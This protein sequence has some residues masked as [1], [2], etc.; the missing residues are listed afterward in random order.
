MEYNGNLVRL[1]TEIHEYKGKQIIYLQYN[2]KTL[3]K[4][5]FA[6]LFHNVKYGC[7]LSGINISET[8]LLQLLHYK[9]GFDNE[10][11]AQVCGYR[12]ATV[13]IN[14]DYE[15]IDINYHS[16]VNLYLEMTL[17]D[18]ETIEVIADDKKQCLIRR[19]N[20]YNDKMNNKSVNI[21][22]EIFEFM[23][24]F[25]Q[26]DIFG[27]RTMLLSRLL[28]Q[29]LLFKSNI[30]VTQYQSIDRLIFLD[31]SN[32]KQKLRKKQV[33]LFNFQ[34][35]LSFQDY[36]FMKLIESYEALDYNFQLILDTNITPKYRVLN[37]LN[38][39]F[40][41]IS[42]SELEIMLA[43]ISRKTIERALVQLQKEVLIE[44]VG[45][46]KAT[47]YKVK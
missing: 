26:S 32:G 34:S 19:C 31:R 15:F 8:K 23:Y 46:G 16:I 11:E 13:L 18:T 6:A 12:D 45:Q 3:E 43:D 28:M 9:K 38:R 29:L 27:K 14:E 24:Q 22:T 2:N 25:I 17:G 1:M 21:L 36:Y 30:L 44:K 47:K 20:E 33:D 4:L 41:P 40:D 42:R 37:V 5:K 7:A 39:S 35:V 10:I